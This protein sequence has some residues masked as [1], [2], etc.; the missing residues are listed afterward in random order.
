M[1][2]FAEP[3]P[4][5]I[6]PAGSQAVAYNVSGRWTV[7]KALS[8]LH[9]QCDLSLPAAVDA[10]AGSSR[11]WGEWNG[12]GAETPTTNRSSDGPSYCFY[13]LNF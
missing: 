7:R 13:L 4:E 1:D 3:A 8:A 5:P 6:E 10:S 12:A 11:L 2:D 9:C